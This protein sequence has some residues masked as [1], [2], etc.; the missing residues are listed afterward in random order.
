MQH[1]KRSLLSSTL[2]LSIGVNF[3]LA[4]LSCIAPCPAKAQITPDGT[5]G[6]KSSVVVPNGSIDQ[7]SGGAIQ[8]SNLFHSFKEFNVG[9]GAKAYFTNPEGITNI[10]TRVTGSNASNILG[11]LGVSGNGNANLFLI[12]PNG[13][14]FGSNASLD[15]RGSFVA[16]SADSLVFDNRLEFSAT[17]PQAPPLL[18]VN[19]PVGLRLRENS[20]SIVNQSSAVLYLPAGNTLALVG[21]NVSL[22]GGKLQVPG[23]RIELGGLTGAGIVGLNVQESQGIPRVASLSF[24]NSIERADVSLSQGAVVNVQSKGGGSIAIN[25]RNLNIV[26]GGRLLAGIDPHFDSPETQARN[27]EI[28]ATDQVVFSGASSGALNQVEIGGQGNSGDINI[29]ARSLEVREGAQLGAST[30]GKGDAGKINITATDKVLFDGGSNP[31]NFSYVYSQVEK[32]AEGNSGGIEINADSLT[33][34]NGAQLSSSIKGSG[35]AGAIRITATDKVLFDGESATNNRTALQSQVVEEAVGKSGD[36]VIKT[37]ILEVTNGAFLDTSIKGKG[38]GQ[39]GAIRITATDKVLLDGESKG[40]RTALLSQVGEEAVGKSGDIVIETPILMVTNSAFLDTSTKGSGNAGA[41]RITATDKVLFDGETDNGFSSGVFS[42]V[43]ERAVGKSGDIVIE[44]P[45][46]QVTNGAFLDAS[47]KGSGDAGAIRI[48]ATD[49]VIFDGK[50]NGNSTYVASL[51][52]NEAVGKSGSIVIETPILKVTNG[53]KVITTTLGKGNS[54]LIQVTASDRVFFDGTSTISSEVGAG[55]TGGSEGIT[56]K[57][58]RLQI[59]NAAIVSANSNGNG[60]AGNIEITSD[61]IKLSSGGQIRTNTSASLQ[62]GNITLNVPNSL[63]L[64]DFGTAVLAE[65]E[66]TSTSAGGNIFVIGSPKNVLIQNGAKLSV[67]SQG[68]GVGGDI[69]VQANS[70]TLDQGTISAETAKET[71][72]NIKLDV[73]DLLLM[74]G[75]SKISTSAGIESQPGAIGTGGNIKIDTQFLVAPPSK[76]N[77]SDITANATYGK[78]GRVDITATGIFGIEFRDKPR[79]FLNDITASSEFGGNPGVININRLIDPS[80]N[81]VELPATIVNPNDQIAQNPCSKGV[82][83]EFTITGRGGLPPSPNEDLSQEAT[84]VG[85]VEPVS[86]VSNVKPPQKTSSSH[87]SPSQIPS[88]IVPAQGWIFNN[89]G[90]VILTAYNPKVTEIHRLPKKLDSCSA[91]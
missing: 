23:G 70:L 32:G 16:S 76:P 67:N 43:V 81:L 90:E 57:A 59:S 55:A 56:I 39:A 18:T 13:I 7:I 58:P 40:N 12:N 26:G 29:K 22:D 30:S 79:D 42:Q 64:S 25:S 38:S 88:P 50:N 5:L 86:T 80:R 19:I 46:L 75:D 53:A 33:V 34:T 20:A 84:Q 73:A 62:A 63:T 45:I 4:L 6:D 65:T 8:G 52:G 35:N 10:L 15:L 82:A 68:S 17:N 61:T 21:G 3:V 49:N 2:P 27:I 83:S 85:L 47:T 66:K 72:G 74:S 69:S 48:T 28:N 37:P 14:V 77:G 36:I 9:E 51:V 1:P 31:T 60:N 41:I 11:T 71:G 24:P 89:K 91:R 78:G 87:N 54:G 44:T